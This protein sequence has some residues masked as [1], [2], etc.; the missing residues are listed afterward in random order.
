M[1][2]ETEQLKREKLVSFTL[3]LSLSFP[4]LTYAT[5]NI[6]YSIFG[7][8]LHFVTVLMYVFN[9][10][11]IFC[12]C[13][14]CMGRISY[15]KF[16]ITG[17]LLILLAFSYAFNVNARPYIWTKLFDYQNNPI[18]LF[19]LYGYVAFLLSD[20]IHDVSLFLNMLYKFSKV[21]VVFAAIHYILG[22]IS[23]SYPSYMT[24]SYNLLFPT[25]F[26]WT[27]KMNPSTLILAILGS[28][29][30]LI[31]GC[32]GALVC[33]IMGVLVFYLFIRQMKPVNRFLMIFGS[34]ILVLLLI[35]FWN[36]ILSAIQTV[37]EA[38]GL[39]SRT[40][41][42]LAGNDFLSDSGRSRIIRILSNRVRVFGYGLFGDRGLTN[43]RYA[44]NIFYELI[45]DFGWPVGTLLFIAWVVLIIFALVKSDIA[46]RQLICVL[47]PGGCFKLF[48]SGSY[49]AQEPA[50]YMLLGVCINSVILYRERK[51]MT[52]IHLPQRQRGSVPKPAGGN[53]K[54]E[55]IS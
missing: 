7:T 16:I 11:T 2:L 44:H 54:L 53:Q 36:T 9:I 55:G 47:L 23:G 31:A 28:L 43:G 34:I 35:V 26:L 3:C 38:L 18:Y 52:T 46:A 1:N 17:V 37:T 39:S 12:A 29:L 33:L 10:V 45:I 40:V 25:A 48:L 19:F 14:T 51:K 27:C 30:I 22:A 8:S 41:D 24:F 50:F 4:L 13:F 49:L 42:K 20:Y 32:R 15:S 6:I 21:S 5:I